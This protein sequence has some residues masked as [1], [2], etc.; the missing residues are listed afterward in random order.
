MKIF[1][2][3]LTRITLVMLVFL[4]FS[5]E[6]KAQITMPR[7]FNCG[8][9]L[10]EGMEVPVWG[11]ASPHEK[12]TVSID[13]N[14]VKTRADNDGK[15]Q[16]KLPEMNAGG[17]YSMKIK[18]NNTIVFENIMVGEVWVC[19][20]QSNMEFPVDSIDQSYRG[21]NNYRKEMADA[22]N[23]PE[24]RLF[25]VPRK[26]AQ[27]PQKDMDDG[28]WLECSSAT[29][30]DFSAVGYFFAR[31]LYKKL[32]VPIGMICSSW[33]GTVAESWT[34]PET[35]A[36]DSDFAPMLAALQKLDLKKYKESKEAAIKAKLGDLPTVDKGLV[37]GKAVWAAPD[38]DDSAWKSMQLPGLW[39][40]RGYESI[41]G[42]A[43][44]RKTIEISPE[45]AGKAAKLNLQ[46]ID[47]SD[48]TWV[49]GIPVGKTMNAYDK[50][51][52][53][54]IPEGLLKTGK[55]VITVRVED[56]G[57]GGGIYGSANQLNL[58]I[59]GKNIPLAGDW[60]FK[61]G[62]IDT[63]AISLGP[64]DYPTLLYNGMVSP[65]AGYGIKGVIWYQGESNA[66]RPTQYQRI[67]PNLIKDW[68]M[69]WNEGDFPFL[70][71]Q[72]A[73]YMAPAK[74][75]GDSN[76]ARLR[77]AQTKT[78]ALPNTGMAVAIDIGEGGNI[79]PKNKQ[80]VGY[81]LSLPALKIA[82]N[83]DLVYS[84][85]MYDYMD[86]DKSRVFLTFNHVGDG[87]KVRDKYGYLKGFAVAGA[88]KKFHWA[89]AVVVN[90]TTVVV[91]SSEVKNPVAVRYGWAD[92]PDD[93][94]LYNSADLPA[95]PFRTDNW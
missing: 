23:Y 86:I 50:N 58:Q 4:S 54:D 32:G 3:N 39:E 38:F 77:E 33:G 48:Q 94:N 71:V 67:F 19:S 15:W 1:L 90:P 79:H 46:K 13:G 61:F 55:N 70:F 34:S 56:T 85:P 14:T 10:Q 42:I 35:M 17:P 27:T 7:I 59:D 26:I 93:V 49:N 31:D 78:L 80:S 74:E 75:P 43:W 47:D 73:N 82:Y 63:N 95:S 37:D 83:K 20:G 2:S 62:K 57:G 84:G 40:S 65:I 16:L 89:K 45:D 88:D 92:N 60:K 72:L 29:V 69:H 5:L 28:E 53:Y 41:D 44:F 87:L 64:N 12:V 51:R 18:G 81:R 11:W 76:W 6:G 9:V 66:D 25:T 52:H 24:I 30:G 68:R 22:D 21:V 36:N 91:F 8:M